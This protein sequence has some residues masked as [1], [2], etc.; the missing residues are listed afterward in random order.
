MVSN[1][2]PAPL[3]ANEKVVIVTESGHRYYFTLR[4]G[5][6]LHTSEGYF[7]SDEMEGKPSGAAVTSNTGVRAVA[8]RPLLI[9][10][11]MSMPRR[12]QVTYPKDLGFI[13]VSTGIGP[14]SIVVEGGTGSGILALFIANYVRPGGM[15]IS[16]DI[17][18]EY[19]PAVMRH[20]EL[21]G[22]SS[23]IRLK[24]GDMSEGVEERDVDAFIADVPEPWRLARP[25]LEAL[26]PGGSFAAII[27]T[28]D[29]LTKTCTELRKNGFLEYFAG[30]LLLRSWRVKEG[31]TRPHHHMRGHT[32]YI[33][34]ARRTEMSDSSRWIHRLPDGYT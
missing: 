12:T 11:L 7:A 32:V 17:D 16:Y 19:F 22:L 4:K 10:S 13:L 14:G 2:R 23:Y 6:R 27:P 5:S 26:K 21:L 25:A 8:F 30:E 24:R 33:V 29:Q 15:V 18:D 9:E 28:V 1:Q 20:A 3:S 31:M 34:T